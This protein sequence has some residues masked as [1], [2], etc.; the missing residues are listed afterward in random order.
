MKNEIFLIFLSSI[1]L[2]IAI[3]IWQELFI[4]AKT[5]IAYPLWAKSLPYPM[6]GAHLITLVSLAPVA[7]LSKSTISMIINVFITLF[8][9]ITVATTV[10]M[11]NNIIYLT[12][13]SISGAIIWFTF[14]CFPPAIL[15][16]IIR[17]SYY[18]INR[19]KAN[20]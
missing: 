5:T 10:F 9:S 20:E 7:V 18:A 17:V 1:L 3:I 15:L 6:S 4:F 16:I 19:K 14:L 2:I 13:N 12:F 11:L 8:I